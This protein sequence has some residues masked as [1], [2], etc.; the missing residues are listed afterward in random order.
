MKNILK[1]ETRSWIYGVCVAGFGVL[2]VYGI[3]DDQA[4]AAYSILAA[5]VFGLARGN[6][7]YDSRE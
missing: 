4:I 1:P 2:G 7:D 5:A 3:M 6:V